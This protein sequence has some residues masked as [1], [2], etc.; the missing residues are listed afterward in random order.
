[1]L[2][3]FVPRV[4][5]PNSQD[6]QITSTLPGDVM[7]HTP[8]LSPEYASPEHMADALIKHVIIILKMSKYT[9]SPCH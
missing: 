8:V 5:K 4:R 2:P 6:R 9:N 1:M 7:S 3:P